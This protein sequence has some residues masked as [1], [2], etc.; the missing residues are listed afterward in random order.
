[1]IICQEHD[2]VGLAVRWSNESGQDEE[3]DRNGHQLFLFD[4]IFVRRFVQES[5]FKGTRVQVSEYTVGDI[6]EKSLTGRSFDFEAKGT[7]V[8]LQILGTT[9]GTV[10]IYCH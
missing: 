1:M 5:Q 6:C 4:H 9:F 8:E 10:A 7:D 2:K 3:T